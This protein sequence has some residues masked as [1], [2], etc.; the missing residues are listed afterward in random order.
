M[1]DTKKA[2]II[3]ARKPVLGKVK[4]RL[5]AKAGQQKALEIYKLLLAHTRSIASSLHCDNF[6]FVTEAIDDNFWQGFTAE[7]QEGINLG[8]RMNHA[9][10]LLFSKGYQHCIIIGSDCPG[11]SNEIVNTAF[12][13]LHNNDIVIGPATDGGYYLLGMRKMIAGIFINKDWSTSKVFDQ[14]MLDVKSQNLSCYILP[15]L[16]DVDEIED[17]PAEWLDD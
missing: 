17:V 16:T 15:Q 2:L 14:T 13:S 8:N 11:L 7:M 10:D 6:V 4:T 1:T 9:F 3:F 5:A 12:Q